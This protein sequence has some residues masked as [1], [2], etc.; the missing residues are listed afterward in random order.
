M[1]AFL[2]I[3]CHLSPF[4]TAAVRIPMATQQISNKGGPR[5][6][7]WKCQF[8]YTLSWSVSL[9]W[10]RPVSPISGEEIIVF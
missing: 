3:G 10:E 2:E 9:G 5:N 6:R 7:G 8:K 4:Q 1:M